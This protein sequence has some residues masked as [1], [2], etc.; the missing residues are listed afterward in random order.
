[1]LF[2]VGNKDMG[3][4]AGK[5]SQSSS[6]PL[7]TTVKNPDS[8]SINASSPPLS[9]FS[10]LRDFY[11]RE[12]SHMN[13]KVKTCFDQVF[14]GESSQICEINL[15]FINLGEAGMAQLAVVL[16]AFKGLKSLRLWKTKLGVL[17]AKR[18]ATA[19]PKLPLIEVLSLED[20]DIRVE[21]MASISLGVPHI[22]L[23]K[24]LYLH[25][26]RLGLEGVSALSAALTSKSN[27][28][29]LTLDEN[30]VTN[31]GLAVLL[32]ALTSSMPV[33]AHLG[34]GFNM[35]TDA[36]AGEVLKVL[37]DM[38]ELKK[39]TLSGNEISAKMENRL[40]KAAPK[41]HIAY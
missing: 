30:Q 2:I 22:P 15:K 4:C 3:S 20:N 34:L 14:A 31:E 7:R 11:T 36:G 32:K 21:G 37:D 19:L 10:D 18:L 8:Q 16:P 12:G 38:P 1:L 26:N 6:A 24:E 25:V 35:L 5:K 40:A 28:E 17:G 23:L 9:K 41:L 33:L 39:L 27:L 13:R 29:A